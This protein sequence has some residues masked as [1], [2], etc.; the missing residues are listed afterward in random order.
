[1]DQHHRPQEAADGHRRRILGTLAVSVTTS[2]I[3]LI[4]R[5]GGERMGVPAASAELVS[6]MLCMAAALVM[7]VG[8]EP[9]RRDALS[10][11]VGT[12]QP[13]I[14]RA[15]VLEVLGVSVLVALVSRFVAGVPW[16]DAIGRFPA[17][18]IYL[19]VFQI[20]ARRQRR[21]VPPW[22]RP[23]GYGFALAGLSGGLT[24]AA[25][26]GASLGHGAAYGLT[27]SLMHYIYVRVSTLG[28]A[29]MLEGRIVRGEP[30]RSA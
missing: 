15:V 17:I 4:L 3:A 23:A 30:P 28:A 8:F 16:A 22:I 1:M 27:G 7:A 11:T 29:A 9:A 19:T 12:P 6:I 24:W 5:F 21:G 25:I 10:Q 14:T 20:L 13:S 2:V 18:V 26:A